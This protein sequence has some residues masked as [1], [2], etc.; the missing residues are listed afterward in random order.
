M[1]IPV[2]KSP[3]AIGIDADRFTDTIYIANSKDD[4]VS[5][6]DQDANKVVV[7]VTFNITPDN[8]GHIECDK[9]NKLFA[10]LAQQFYLWSGSQCTAIPNQ[11]FEF[12]SWQKNLGGNSSQV[13]QVSPPSQF[14]DSI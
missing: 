9:D 2:G 1:R 11:G 14:L 3:R 8:A 13:I 12:V 6:I 10:P 5:V 7:G 4:T